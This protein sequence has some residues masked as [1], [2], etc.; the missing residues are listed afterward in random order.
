M[1]VENQLVEVKWCNPVKKWYEERGYQFTKNRDSFV[2]RAE[3]LPITSTHKVDVQCDSCGIIKHLRCRD[4]QKSI[5]K[6]GKY[7]CRNCGNKI[8]QQALIEN[9]KVERFRIFEEWCKKNNYKPVSTIDDYEN[10]KSKLRF[11]CP[12][13]GVGSVMYTHVQRGQMS[14]G[15][16]KGDRLKQ[17]H[18][19][20]YKIVKEEIESKNNNILINPEDYIDSKT[21]NLRVICGSCGNQFI[22]SRALIKSTDGRCWECGRNV[23]NWKSFKNLVQKR[24]QD[25]VNR[26]REL[27]YTAIMSVDDFEE[28]TTLDSVRILCPK[29]GEVQQ[30][31]YNFVNYNG[32]CKYCADEIRGNKLKYNTEE[33][34][35][36]ISSKNNN[37]LLNPEEYIGS[38]ERN[39]KIKCG[40]CGNV[41]IQSL[42][43]YKR[44]NLTGKCPD[45]NEISYGEYLI[46]S[47]LNK[48]R[49]SYNRWHP[50]PDCRDKQP[51]PFDFYLEEYNLCIEYD[52]EQH[53]YPKF[54]I[55]NFVMTKLHDAMKNQYCKWNN[56]DLLRIPYW[57][58]D[59]IEQILI[60]YLHLTPQ[61]NF[62]PTKIKYIPN[63]KTA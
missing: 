40:S 10:T 7:Y 9:E 39:L 24:H 22:T 52:G 33:L 15:C 60:D 16:C 20:P 43:N 50:F 26:C 25:Y 23:K 37:T 38:N 44:A 12:I 17:I 42:N 63:R 56:I 2:V 34:L 61:S 49:I 35:K 11:E 46:A 8:A 48:Y 14:G 28:V 30:L 4:Y 21:K 6:Y 54:G 51:L 58:R 32:I 18:T 27:G 45:C 62:K 59:N 19:T 55:D 41:F 31:Y 53:F 13:H 3:D 57:D 36:I 1:L 5:M 47:Y 29:H